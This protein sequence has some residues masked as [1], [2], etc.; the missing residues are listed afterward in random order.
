MMTN[1]ATSVL[2]LHSNTP[3]KQASDL[4]LVFKFI[5]NAKRNGYHKSYSTRL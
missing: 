4:V 1:E 3:K 5:T 2:S